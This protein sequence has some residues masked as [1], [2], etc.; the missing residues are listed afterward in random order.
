MGRYGSSCPSD[1]NSSAVAAH[2]S[3]V[4]SPIPPHPALRNNALSLPAL[5]RWR[6]ILLVPD[7]Q[8]LPGGF[9]PVVVPAPTPQR[10]AGSRSQNLVRSLGDNGVRVLPI[11]PRTLLGSTSRI[12]PFLVNKPWTELAPIGEQFAF[13]LLSRSASYWFFPVL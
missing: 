9:F 7:E 11:V 10:L 2:P 4:S 13:D 12:H 6:P 5:W 3:M 1:V 8:Q